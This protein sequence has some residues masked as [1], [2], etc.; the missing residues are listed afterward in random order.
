MK[1][2]LEF[3]MEASTTKTTSKKYQ[4]TTAKYQPTQIKSFFEIY[5]F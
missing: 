2:L 4:P 5:T 1:T 3:N